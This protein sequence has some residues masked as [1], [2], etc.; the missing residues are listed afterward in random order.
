M[1]SEEQALGFVN[2][3]GFCTAFTAGLEVPCLREAIVGKREPRLPHHIQRTRP[4]GGKDELTARR[5]VYYGKVIAGPPA[6]IAP[7]M[8]PAFLSLRAERVP[9]T[10]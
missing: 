7:R 10:S 9:L 4:D 8:L 1:K 6:F 5:A 3:V 2:E